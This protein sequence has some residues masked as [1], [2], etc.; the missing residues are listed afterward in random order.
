MVDRRRLGRDVARTRERQALAVQPPDDD[1]EVGRSDAT[2]ASLMSTTTSS[3][4]GSRAAPQAFD[5]L[6]EMRR[7]VLDERQHAR[8]GH[9]RAHRSR[10]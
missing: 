5:E 3:A 7:A 8:A 10:R 9:R 2:G 4:G 6:R 1:R